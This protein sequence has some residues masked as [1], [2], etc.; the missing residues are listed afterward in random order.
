VFFFFFPS[1][2][3]CY[4]ALELGRST[5]PTDKEDLYYLIGFY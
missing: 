2:N 4:I 5:L 3:T 1:L